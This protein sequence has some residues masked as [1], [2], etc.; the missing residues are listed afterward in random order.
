MPEF[1]DKQQSLVFL[2][3]WCRRHDCRRD[4]E[5]LQAQTLPSPWDDREKFHAAAEYLDRRMERI[6]Q[7]LADYL[8]TQLLHSGDL[9]YWRILIGTWLMHS[10]Q[11]HAGGMEGTRFNAPYRRFFWQPKDFA[12]RVGRRLERTFKRG[13]ERNLRSDTLMAIARL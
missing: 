12:E 10:L 7:P 11:Q 8:N 1:W 3:P 13:L 2:G 5:D 6:L 4:W 9:R